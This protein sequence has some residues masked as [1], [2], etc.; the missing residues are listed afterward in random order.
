MDVRGGPWGVIKQPNLAEGP[1]PLG[2]EPSDLP[3]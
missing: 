1:K 2:L 3:F